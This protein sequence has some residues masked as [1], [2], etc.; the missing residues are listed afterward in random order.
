MDITQTATPGSTVRRRHDR[1]WIVRG[2]RIR[3]TNRVRAEQAET[4]NLSESGALIRVGSE[5]TFG[6]GDEVEILV[7]WDGE[8]V[9]QSDDSIRGVV[10]RVVPM[11]YHHQAIGVEFATRARV[12]L[13]IPRP[14]VRAAA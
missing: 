11:D 13:P 3:A 1:A 7:A 6:V 12:A 2:C 4:T 14:F 10:R 5:G 8:A 9:V